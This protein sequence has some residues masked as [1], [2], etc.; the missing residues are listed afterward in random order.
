MS[1]MNTVGRPTT[2]NKV[3]TKPAT[4]TGGR[5]LL[6]DEHLI[7]ESDG[8]GKTGVDLPEPKTDGSDLGDL[9]R[10]LRT[11]G[12]GQ[13]AQGQ[14][15]TTD[16]RYSAFHGL[17]LRTWFLAS[18]AGSCRTHARVQGLRMGLAS[19]RLA[20]SSSPYCTA[21]GSHLRGRLRR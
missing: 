9:V 15:Q 11:N 1:T 4:L 19:V 14:A 20:S 17:L 7:F 5:G 3:E 8:W 13:R 12:A 18:A 2:P 10:R 16:Y 6:Q 21:T